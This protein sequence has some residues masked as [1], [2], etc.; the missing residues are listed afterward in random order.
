MTDTAAL[1]AKL[2][3]AESTQWFQHEAADTITTLTNDLEAAKE[4]I[5]EGV[6]I[7]ET[8][9]TALEQISDQPYRETLFT[10]PAPRDIATAALNKDT[11]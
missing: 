10:G 2:R 1:V 9:T 8:L 3:Q 4:F 7:M 5:A 11:T 6:T